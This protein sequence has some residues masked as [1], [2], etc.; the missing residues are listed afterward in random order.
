MAQ[1]MEH[2]SRHTREEVG[3]AR[4]ITFQ[5]MIMYNVKNPIIIDQNYCDKAKPCGE[6]KS[7]VQ[8]S[9][10]V[11][12]NI[13]GTTITK[14]AIKMNCSKNV[15]CHGITLKNIDLKMKAGERNTESI[16]ENAKWRKSGA[17][18]PQPCA[19]TK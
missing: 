18:V 14:D 6:Q 12:R 9:N 1:P 17:V 8:V 7:A 16:C 10:V 19:A 4:D 15:P 3:Y 5:N 2:A 11:F 13:R